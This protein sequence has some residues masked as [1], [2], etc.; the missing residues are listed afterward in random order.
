VGAA[1]FASSATCVL[2]FLA[3]LAVTDIGTHRIPNLLTVSAASLGVLLN[4]RNAGG[5]GVLMSA[6]GM[7]T[8]LAIFLPFYFAKGFGAGDVKAM[9]AVGAFVGPHGAMLAAACTLIAGAICALTLL[10]VRRERAAIA[11]LPRRWAWQLFAAYSTGQPAPLV[12]ASVSASDDPTRRRFPYGLAIACGTAF[13]LLW[14][15]P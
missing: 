5:H 15:T 3:A 8:G 2:T 13:S 11:S 6:A 10:I 9:G 1:L 7:L 4:F 12:S 14:S